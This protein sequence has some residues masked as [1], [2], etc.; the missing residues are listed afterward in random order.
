LGSLIFFK[1]KWGRKLREILQIAVM[2]IEVLPHIFKEAERQLCRIKNC[3]KS[4]FNTNHSKS[5]S[6]DLSLIIVSVFSNIPDYVNQRNA[7]LK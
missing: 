1:G 5:S 6:A 4:N 2:S 7:G 3:G